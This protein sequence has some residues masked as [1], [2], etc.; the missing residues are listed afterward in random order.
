[1]ANIGNVKVY[2]NKV[3]EDISKDIP[4]I[5]THNG[6]FH[7]DEVLATSLLTLIK[8][9]NNG[10]ILRSRNPDIW[11]QCD[12]LVDVG[13]VYDP[14]QHRYDHHQNTF[15]ENIGMGF[16]TRL[17]SAGLVYKHFGKQIL[18]EACGVEE[19]HLEFVYKYLY[20]NFFEHIDAIDNGINVA[21]GDLKY[22]ITTTLSS[23]VGY[24]NPSWNTPSSE[25][26]ESERFTQAM[27]L[28]RSEFLETVNY[29]LKVLI[30]ARSIV[31]DAISKR[32]D[33]HKSGRVIH[34]SQQCPW[35]THLYDLERELKIEGQIL[36]VL[37]GD[38]NGNY[39][40]QCVSKESSGFENRLSI[41]KNWWGIRGEDLDKLVGGNGAIFVHASGFIGG[42]KTFE[43]VMSMADQSLSAMSDD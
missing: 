8:P 4:K 3:P 21:D 26:D 16:T 40:I 38:L 28:T 9:Y 27:Q 18:K 25:V 20:K 35:K 6:H 13:A 10:V 43:G 39:R 1:M 42:H 14:S 36:F 22:K 34:L 5:G 17:S 15:Q 32:F 31:E 12:V 24:F 33:V 19:K 41:V 2:S 29:L 7:C 11:N 23:R 30:P 37:Y